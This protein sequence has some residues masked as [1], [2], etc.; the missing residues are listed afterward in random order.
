MQARY[1][2]REASDPESRVL[3]KSA[4]VSAS[5]STTYNILACKAAH[6]QYL[7]AYPLPWEQPGPRWPSAQ[8]R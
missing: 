2:C 5:L 3:I 1:P 4:N 7:G 6:A 8:Q